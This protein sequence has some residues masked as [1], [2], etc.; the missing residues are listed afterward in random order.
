MALTPRLDLRQSQTLVMTPQLQQA[1]K[2][3][4]LSNIE[5]G[6]YVEQYLE[7][8]PLLER[9]DAETTGADP[10]GDE[11]AAA[12][13]ESER[14][15]TQPAVDH[16]VSDEAGFATTNALDVDTDDL[17]DTDA[18]AGQ[19]E[20]A[21][22]VGTSGGETW[23][24][25]GRDRGENEQ[26]GEY[27][28]R[29]HKSLRDHILEQISIELRD[30]IDR[31]I[32]CYLTELLDESGYLSDD[33]ESVSLA[34]SCPVERAEKVL[35]RL[36]NFDPP[37][38]FAR[39]L[40]ECLMLQLRERGRLDPVMRLL[41]DNLDLLAKRDLATLTRMCGVDAE[42]IF[43]KLEE[44]RSL[45]P[46]PALAYD[47]TV[48][49]PIIPDI[50]MRPHPRG[51]WIVELNSETLPR[52]LV[53]S[54][55]YAR[56]TRSPM[57]K[58]ERA[59]INE[60]L[61]SANWLVKAL[62]Q[63]ASTILKV[64]IEIIR[65]QE[66]FFLRGV[67]AL[68]PLVLR[69]IAEEVGLHESTISRVTSNKYLSS[70]RGIYELK[71]FFSQAVGGAPGVASHS[72]EWVRHRIREVIDAEPPSQVLTDDAIVEILER[73][74][75]VVARRTVAKYREALGVPSSV[76]RRREKTGRA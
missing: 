20:A 37:G 36:Q 22:A 29:E 10:V 73:E 13:A 32:G 60:C 38:I 17:F 27:V 53:N 5:L 15:A 42:V 31:L 70:P 68:R 63:R 76:Q 57:R 25:A 75:I 28:V 62:N 33:L 61:Q 4:Q 30:P 72:A 66:D 71:Y 40:A 41:L 9:D 11:S 16:A 19:A 58:E 18:S 67:Q 49:Q 64:S 51:G 59:Y 34:L 46:K 26:I 3:L 48:I 65:Q 54:S 43:S 44:I 47:N 8:N 69:D 24:S 14:G 6:P 21:L 1:I 7:Q 35:H 2:L 45:N 55:Y 52:I 56:I 50:L 74:G 39:N 23:L 12:N